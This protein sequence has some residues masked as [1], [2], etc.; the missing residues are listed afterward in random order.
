LLEWEVVGEGVHVV[1]LKVP[2]L[3]PSL[4][5]TVP[6]GADAVPG[7]VSVTVLVSVIGEKFPIVV[8]ALLGVMAAAVALTTEKEESPE[9]AEYVASPE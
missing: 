7:L 5:D 8:D 6:D 4:Q 2:L 9:L 1:E 3:P